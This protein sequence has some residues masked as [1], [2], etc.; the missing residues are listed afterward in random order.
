MSKIWLVTGAARG[1]GRSVVEAA[2][3]AGDRVVATAR[4]PERLADLEK[5][6]GGNLRTFALDVTDADAAKAAID[7]TV[8]TFSGLDV[9]VNNAGVGQISPFE[10]ISLADFR[11]Q[12]DVNFYGVVNLT[13]AALPVLRKQRAGY[14]INISS[15]AG[16]TAIPTLAAYTAAKWAV[17]GF[18]EAL[19]TEVKALGIKVTSVEPGGMRTE[20]ASVAGSTVP[21]LLPEYQASVGWILDVI[22]G[23]PGHEFGDPARV[24]KV[25][26]DLAGRDEVPTHLL[27]GTDALHA[28]ALAEDA[29]QKSDAEWK[30][31]SIS[32]NFSPDADLSY[33]ESVKG[34]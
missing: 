23:T 11:A 18:T 30:A 3:A 34:N 2:L 24:A 12:I 22:K 7:F 21:E 29:R 17:G 20:W 27:L 26:V 31:V 6:H 14:I 28:A 1:L 19:S 33:F 10:Q 8:R 25:V 32:T 16:R 4:N 9:L 13:H 15:V 5:A